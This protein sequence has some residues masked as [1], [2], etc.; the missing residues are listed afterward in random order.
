[1]TF[2]VPLNYKAILQSHFGSVD[3]S[4][5]LLLDDHSP[6]TDSTSTN[7]PV[8]EAVTSLD[9]SMSDAL[10]ADDE[11]DLMS[12]VE[13]PSSDKSPTSTELDTDGIAAAALVVATQTCSSC[14]KAFEKS[15]SHQG[16]RCWSCKKKSQSQLAGH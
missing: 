16:T 5:P 8:S 13:P 3:S 6:G 2:G 14:S 9:V 11:M 15:K 7:L 1:M 10:A 4:E 12:L